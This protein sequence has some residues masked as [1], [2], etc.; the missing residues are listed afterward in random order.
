MTDPIRR[1]GDRLV[2]SGVMTVETASALLAEG[3]ASLASDETLF[4]LA[5]VAEVDSSGLAVVFGWL[6]AARAQGKSLRIVNA[7][8]NLLSLAEVYGVADTLPLS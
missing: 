5:A 4:D 2:V 8:R 7:P 3:V 6:R 1:D